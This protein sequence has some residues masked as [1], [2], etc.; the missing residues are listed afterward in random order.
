MSFTAPRPTL[1]GSTPSANVGAFVELGALQHDEAAEL[2]ARRLRHHEAHRGGLLR[3]E[4][5]RLLRRPDI[6]GR[7]ADDSPDEEVEQDEERDLQG[8]QGRLDLRGG[9][10]HYCGSRLKTSSVEPIVK[11]V[12]SSS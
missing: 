2:V 5:H 7:R 8:E 9:Q 4:D 6:A 10:E 12:P 3:A 1:S 11:R